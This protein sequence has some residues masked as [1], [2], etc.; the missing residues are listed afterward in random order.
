MDAQGRIWFAEFAANKVAM[1]D[2]KEEN[3]K[4]WEAPTPHTYPYDVFVDR[5]GE[6][7][8]GSMSGDRILRLDPRT[9]ASARVPAAAPDQCPAR[10]RRQFNNAGDLLGRQQSRRIDRQAAAARLS[11]RKRGR[12]NILFRASRVRQTRGSKP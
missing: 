9:G 4:E 12:R 7:W 6:L 11:G 10:F 3:F 1:F 8:S 5:N 2:P